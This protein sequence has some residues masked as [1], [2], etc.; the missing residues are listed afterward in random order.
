MIVVQPGAL[1]R[2]QHLD[3][4]Q[5]PVDRAQ[6][7]CLEPHEPVRVRRGDGDQSLGADPP[8]TGPVASRLVRQKHARLERHGATLGNACRPFMNLH[9]MPYPVAGAMRIIEADRPHR[10]ARQRVNLLAGGAFRKT[11][12]RHRDV[13]TQNSGKGGDHSR[14]R[15]ADGNGAGD[16]GG[17]IIVMRAGIDQQQAV[18][19]KHFVLPLDGTVMHDRAIRPG[20]ADRLEA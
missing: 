18:L 15:R 14:R 12:R 2:Q 4:D 17:A 13:A 7:D 16:V 10:R 6:G 3:I 11:R 5:P 19:D 1:G 8:F 9:H 20:P